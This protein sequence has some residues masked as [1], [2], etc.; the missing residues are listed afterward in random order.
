M[1]PA[2]VCSTGRNYECLLW[3]LR[4]ETQ[5]FSNFVWMH[6]QSTG[7]HSPAQA[8]SQISAGTN[9]PSSCIY[10]FQWP[11][12]KS[13][14]H[15]LPALTLSGVSPHNWDSA[16]QGISLARGDGCQDSAHV[17]KQ[18]VPRSQQALPQKPPTPP[19]ASSHLETKAGWGEKWW[20]GEEG[21][22]QQCL[23]KHI[24]NEA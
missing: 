12:L 15:T 11:K 17:V 23:S 10:H 20:G 5:D 21:K 6:L 22:P 1:C 16:S 13:I 2:N 14:M 8:A 9:L 19:A 4:P 18:R 24:W 3:S 7:W